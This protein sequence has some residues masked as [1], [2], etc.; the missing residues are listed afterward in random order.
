MF[1]IL[2]SFALMLPGNNFRSVIAVIKE[3]FATVELCDKSLKPKTVEFVKQFER[4]SQSKIQVGG[5][6][7]L[8]K[9]QADE[10][11]QKMM[12]LQKGNNKEKEN[13]TI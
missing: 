11:V 8:T 12:E 3:P 2:I 7:C 10:Y 5:S 13:N 1:F 9:E 4:T 6:M